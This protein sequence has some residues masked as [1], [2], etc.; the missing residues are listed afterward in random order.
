MPRSIRRVHIAVAPYN[1]HSRPSLALWCSVTGHWESNRH[2]HTPDYSILWQ[3]PLQ[4]WVLDCDLAALATPVLDIWATNH[5]KQI[6]FLKMYTD[7]VTSL[8]QQMQQPA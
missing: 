1:I 5:D 2:P 6:V 4:V 7:I 8:L 3:N